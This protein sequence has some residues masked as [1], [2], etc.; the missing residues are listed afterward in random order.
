MNTIW[1]VAGFLITFSG[2][3]HAILGDRWIFNQLKA[4]NMRT[5]YTGEITKIT[6]RWFWHIGSFLIFF[7]AAVVLAMG[8]SDTIIPVESESLVAQLLAIIYAGFIGVLVVVNRK[9]L[10]NLREFPQAILF[11]IFIALL[12]I[13]A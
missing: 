3:I 13:G 9:N 6:V 7:M 2:F 12:L 4:E 5:H 8:F 11:V 1:I 10:A